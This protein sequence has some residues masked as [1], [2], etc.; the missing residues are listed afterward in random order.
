MKN[1]TR[2]FALTLLLAWAT[3]GFAWF[4]NSTP[5]DYTDTRYPIVLVHGMFGF[6]QA[7]LVDYWFGIP[8]ELSKYGATVHVAQVPALESTVARG[9]VLLNQVEELAAIH[10]KVNLIGHSHGGPTARYVA[11][12]RPDLV[13]SVTSVGSPHT[14]SNV[15]DIVVNSPGSSLANTLGNALGG[16]IDLVS[17]GGF[18]QN[19]EASLHDLTSQGSAEFNAL[20]PSAI[21][22]TPCGSAPHQVNG[23]RYYSWS[24]TSVLTNI[25][26][27]SDALLGL[28]SLAFGSEP[29]DGLVG[30]CSSHMGHVIRDNYR[31]NH[32]D[33]VN[34]ILGL[35]SLLETS[36]KAVYRHHA[37]RLKNAGL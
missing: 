10:G 21:P 18:D 28:T 3:P 30:R 14:G 20:A 11:E 15:A 13:A 5:S 16:I 27:P 6:D 19:M 31:M 36:P 26:D 23:I 24:G 1:L 7:L 37:N 2:A 8:S 32:L 17:G 29:N 34:Q 25:L 33:E 35:R 22:T 4:W 9:E 12:V